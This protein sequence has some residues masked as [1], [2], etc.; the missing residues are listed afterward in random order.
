MRRFEAKTTKTNAEDLSH[1]IDLTQQAVE[2][3]TENQAD[4]VAHLGSLP[5]T[6]Q[7][8]FEVKTTE[9]KEDGL[10]KAIKLKQEVLDITRKDN[11]NQAI[12]LASLGDAFQS[13]FEAKITETSADDLKCHQIERESSGVHGG[14]FNSGGPSH[15]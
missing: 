11:P 15:L 4:K 13:R 7:T 3:A 1:A 10:N 6:L 8:R 12:N 14:R 2:A 9:S 5:N